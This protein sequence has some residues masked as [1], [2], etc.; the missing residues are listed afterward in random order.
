M[1]MLM[2]MLTLMRMKQIENNGLEWK[3]ENGEVCFDFVAWIL[4]AF[5]LLLPLL[6]FLGLWLWKA[7]EKSEEKSEYMETTLEMFPLSSWMRAT[8]S[9]MLLGIRDWWFSFTCWI[10][11]LFRS[12]T[13]WTCRKVWSKEFHT[14]ASYSSGK[15]SFWPSSLVVV[16]V[17][18]VVVAEG[19]ILDLRRELV[20]A[21]IGNGREKGVCVCKRGKV[22]RGKR[23]REK[24]AVVRT[25][26]WKDPSPVWL[27]TWSY[28]PTRN[29]SAWNEDPGKQIKLIN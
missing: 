21:M 15:P 8:L 26:Y 1:L 5:G 28:A 12:S 16:V 10:S 25:K 14:S 13:D 22:W 9:T 3:W 20:S 7:V 23:W 2:L 24:M 18:V 19:F 6:P 27:G 11:V 17:V 4:Q 29:L